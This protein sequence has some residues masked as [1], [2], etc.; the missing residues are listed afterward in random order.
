MHRPDIPPNSFGAISSRAPQLYRGGATI[1]GL[2]SLLGAGNLFI[3]GNSTHAIAFTLICIATLGCLWS[4]A[5]KPIKGLP[6]L[7][8]FLLQQGVIYAMPLVIGDENLA[9]IS[10]STLYLSTLSVI[11]L[12]V[13]ALA[14][15]RLGSRAANPPPL[16]RWS[17]FPNQDISTSPRTANLCLALLISSI[18]FYLTTRSGVLYQLL[19]GSL[20]S[21]FPVIR[22]GSDAASM[23]GALIGGIA[24]V[25]NPQRVKAVIY[26]LLLGTIFFLSI[27]DVLLSA[28]TGLILA[29]SVGLAL[30]R[31][32]FP[33]LFLISALALLGFLNQG[34][35]T[36]RDKYW[37]SET[38]TTHLSIAQLPSFYLDWASES[39][40]QLLW[41][42]DDLFEATTKPSSATEGQSLLD[43]IDN[44]QILTF[45]VNAV[46]T[47]ETPT[48]N[49]KTYSLIPPLLVPRFL[50]HDKPRTHEGQVLLNLHFERQKKREDTEKTYIAWGL[51]PESIGNFGIFCGPVFLGLLAGFIIGKL[52]YF[53]IRKELFSIE[54]LIL[55]ALLLKVT[56]SFE[57]VSSVFVTSTFQ[58]LVVVAI[59]SWFVCLW[60]RS[61]PPA[62]APY[63]PTRHPTGP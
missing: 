33:W 62:I 11:L 23:F 38:N 40:E 32:K 39:A 63:A 55:L 9:S 14:G 6:Y 10:S 53:S 54:G 46:E 27:A 30:G 52:E 47:T 61:G 56:T 4:W 15:H 2:A 37:D 21:L 34:K 31:A 8:L 57:M 60:F 16:T 25:N 50:W 36:V 5:A 28:A 45:V 19:P 7:P 58:F 1:L 59:G 12:I 44:L 22:T 24:L 29:T 48:L 26:W 3:N 49:G 42:E 35:F 20:W 51:L 43:R 13:S 17:F 18:A 41:K